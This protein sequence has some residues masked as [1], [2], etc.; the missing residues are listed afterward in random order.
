[1]YPNVEQQYSPA[2]LQYFAWLNN[3]PTGVIGA[4]QSLQ[5]GLTGATNAVNT[6]VADATATLEPYTAS[7]LDAIALMSDLAG[8]NGPEAQA[9]AFDAYKSSPELAYAMAEAEKAITRNA[10]ATGGLQGGAVLEALSENALQLAQ[11]DYGNYFN[12]LGSIA[13]GGQ[14]AA[15]DL[16]NIQSGAGTAIG[17]YEYGTGLAGADL[18]YGA[19]SDIADNISDTTSALA[20][21]VAAQG[22][23]LSQIIEAGGDDLAN[24]LATF[25]TADAETLQSLA[26]ILANITTGSASQTVSLPQLTVEQSNLLGQIGMV[27]AGIG[28]MAGTPTDPATTTEVQ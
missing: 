19:G 23:D 14:A 28:T 21:L 3:P 16:A 5:S 1:M 17:G 9:A 27:L 2:T 15:T 13:G 10:A 22:A 12:R 26:T 6:G 24:L 7:G 4:Q 11:T 8:V 25:G 18:L 20:S